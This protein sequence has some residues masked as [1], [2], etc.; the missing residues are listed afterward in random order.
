MAARMRFSRHV[1]MAAALAVPLLGTT[2]PP[3][4][5]GGGG[6]GGEPEVAAVCPTEITT[7]EQFVDCLNDSFEAGQEVTIADTVQCLPAN[8]TVT[9]TVSRESAQAGCIMGGAGDPNPPSDVERADTAGAEPTCQ[10]PRVLLSCPRPPGF[11]PSYTLCPVGSVSDGVQG[12]NRVEIGEIVDD[13]DNMRMAD[14]PV[15]PG[16]YEP[17]D[18]DEVISKVDGGQGTKNCNQCHGNP[19]ESPTMGDDELSDKFPPDE[20]C[21]ICTDEPGKAAHP[22]NCQQK[23]GG[24]PRPAKAECLSDVC[25]CIDLAVAEDNHP[26]DTDQGRVIQALCHAL[27]EYQQ[28]QGVC[29]SDECPGPTCLD[30]SLEGG[31][32]FLDEDAAVSMVRLEVHGTA[33]TNDPDE[34]VDSMDV[35]GSLSAFN[36]LTR[37]R[38]EMSGFSSFEVHRTGAD[39]TA[40]GA[41][42]ALVDGTP[43][44]VEFEATRTGGD[45]TFT[46]SEA[47]G[48]DPLAGVDGEVGRAAFD[49][50]LTP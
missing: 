38:I 35:T 14:V 13:F 19:V 28:S 32:K 26:L 39:F 18:P 2:C 29:G 9:L 7:P 6:G 5:G 22:G 8:C 31:G 16:P 41:G 43:T 33:A 49:L 46:V 1:A 11:M 34:V 24:D 4:G 21:V 42:T 20:D 17:L 48:G 44:A 23:S 15:P 12:S 45:V 37:T 30:Y 50:T 25:H 10:L 47:G 36:Y 27:E 3:S 40:S